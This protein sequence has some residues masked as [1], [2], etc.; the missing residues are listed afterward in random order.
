VSEGL[1]KVAVT[2]SGVDKRGERGKSKH[3]AERMNQV[4]LERNKKEGTI[5]LLVYGNALVTGH[6]LRQELADVV[7]HGEQHCWVHA[8]GM[9]TRGRCQT[10]PHS[11]Q[12]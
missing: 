12:Q 5:V 6:R 4:H 2:G 11:H 1:A 9:T 7:S 3:A 8:N 10:Q